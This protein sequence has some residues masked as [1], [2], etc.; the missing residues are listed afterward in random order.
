ME[1]L[2]SE[3]CNLLQI[4]V[5]VAE[6]EVADVAR[7]SGLKHAIVEK[8]NSK[9]IVELQIGRFLREQMQ[10]VH[11][12]KQRERKLPQENFITRLAAFSAVDALVRQSSRRTLYKDILAMAPKLLRDTLALLDD[13]Q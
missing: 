12:P 4:R 13:S 6:F 5:W 10:S 9:E 7:L 2:L 11:Q 8:A 1:T 3:H